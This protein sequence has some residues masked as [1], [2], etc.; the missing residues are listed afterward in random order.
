MLRMRSDDYLQDDDD[1]EHDDENDDE[2]DGDD[3]EHDADDESRSSSCSSPKPLRSSFSY[4]F[5]LSR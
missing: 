3:A 5:E 2:H 1:E 4:T